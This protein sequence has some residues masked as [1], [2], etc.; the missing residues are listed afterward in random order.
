VQSTGPLTGSFANEAYW[1]VLVIGLVLTALV[2]F[3]LA[4]VLRRRDYAMALVAERTEAL[5]ESM[6]ELERTQEQL[7]RSE[8]L[9]A[10]GELASVVGHELRNPLGVIMNVLYLLEAAAGDNE[11]MHRHLAT[12]RRETSA[13]TLIVSDLLDYSAGR[14][15][16]LA[17]VQVADLVAEAL[18][19]VPPPAGVQV[20]ERSDPD[21]TVD[22]D[23]D[24]LR[25]AL[26]NL[27]TNGFEAMPDGGVLTVSAT[28]AG[29][30]AQITVTDTGTG[31]SAETR[32]K[33]F[34]PFYTGKVR[35][36]GLGL[37]VTKRVVDAHG[38]TITVESTP[39]VG[40]SFTISVPAATMASVPQ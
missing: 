6:R 34:T 33:I 39:S 17:P 5:E 1:V 18:S 31:M 3:V 28:T 22:A 26:L 2:G 15:P 16:M 36:I 37:A 20:I 29:G 10:I 7:V 40:T 19:V 25:Q 27:I 9:A 21:I 23:R 12:A 24:Q 4:T 30:S 14:Q 11:A 32:E 38:G 8:R 13:A 35:G